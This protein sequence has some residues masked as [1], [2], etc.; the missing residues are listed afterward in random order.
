MASLSLTRK[1]LRPPREN[2]AASLL[3]DRDILRSVGSELLHKRPLAAP[4]ALLH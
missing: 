1:A 4:Q 3:L 2:A